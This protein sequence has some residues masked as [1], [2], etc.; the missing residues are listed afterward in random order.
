MKHRI[1]FRRVLAVLILIALMPWPF[2]Q[3]M[4]RAGW[5]DDW[6]QQ[7]TETSPGYF[8]GQKR[9]YFTGGSFSAR[10][11]Q[12][13][14][15][16]FTAMPPKVKAGCGG[17]DVFLGG[18]S[19]LNF[20][21]LVTK[22][23]RIMQAAPAAAFDIALNVLCEP[24]SK[25]IKSL[26][27]IINTLNSLQLDECK[28]ARALVATVVPTSLADTKDRQA[29]LAGIQGDFLQSSGINDL[30]KSIND[31]TSA[32]AN[33][34]VTDMK[35]ALAG[36]PQD[37]RD[38][39]GTTGSVI[40]N[41][42]AKTGFN[43]PAYL[44]MLR[45]LVG[46]IHIIDAG[47][48]GYQVGHTPPCDENRYASFDNFLDGRVYARAAGGTCSRIDDT[49]A[50]LTNYV[51]TKMNR[52]AGKIKAKQV[53]SD[54]DNAFVNASP[55]SIGLVLKTAV[56]TNQESSIISTL[57]DVT[58]KAYAFQLLSDLYTKAWNIMDKARSLAQAQPGAVQGEQEHRC[59]IEMLSGAIDGTVEMQA[60]IVEM[61]SGVRKSYAVSVQEVM[62]IYN[63]VDKMEK[64]DR[65]ALSM[66]SSKFG[67]AVAAR[68]LS[69]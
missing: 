5:V 32:N 57:S 53:L 22:L 3:G 54:E 39:F 50:D 17:I 44:N 2:C 26:E 60:K 25:T 10:W 47:D 7:K 68:S 16:L 65:L 62:G 49:S 31:Q 27:S 45:G 38:V 20:E 9:G 12:S 11:Q 13:N 56:G 36:C 63:L 66:L 43:H 33:K 69:H 6:L 18:F 59:K 19:Y 8:E 58:A 61:V 29:K 24:C 48:A 67:T 46:D 64:F 37:I 4:P 23:Q 21:Y 35:Q 1:L 41:I 14:D 34:P 55:L 51:R 40:D 42:A 52:I 28:S 30:W 15:Y